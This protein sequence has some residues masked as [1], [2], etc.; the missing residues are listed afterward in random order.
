VR[1][2][3]QFGVLGFS[4]GAIYVALALGLLVI[5]RATA[6]L[7]F[8]QGAMAMWGGYVYTSLRTTGALVLPIGTIH[9]GTESWS[10]ALVLGLVMG[11][12]LSVIV[13]FLVFRPL[14][15]APVLA[16]VVAS[17]AMMIMILSLVQI[18]FGANSLTVPAL[19][20]TG[21]ITIASTSLNIAG[22][23]LA[24]LAIVLC[25][26]AWVFFVFTNAGVA[27]RA[28]SVNERAVMLMGYSP[29]TL[30]LI[31]W[32][33]GVVL[34]TGVVIL[35]SP[36]TGLDPSNYAL[37]VIPALAILLLA[38][39]ASLRT[40]A[41]AGLALGAFQSI[42]TFLSSKTWWPTWGQVGVQD[43]IPFILIVAAL[44]IWGGRLPARGSVDA[45]S[46]PHV[47]L[48][49]LRPPNIIIPLVIAVAA[50]IFT[51]GTYRF[52]VITSLT[53]MLLALSYVLITG[54]LGQISLAQIAFAGASGFILSKI[55]TNWGV[56]F[57]LSIL[58]AALGAGVLGLLLALPAF[59]IRGT[60]LAIVTIAAA[61]TIQEFVFSNPS[62]TPISGNPVSEPS[63]FGLNLAVQNGDDIATLR[64]GL[65]VLI[66]VVIFFGLFIVLARGSTGR[67]WLAVRSNE[68]AAAAAGVNVRAVKLTGFGV[69]AVIAGVAGALIGYSRGQLSADS[70]TVSVGLLL[71]AV[72]YLGG[73]TSLSG[74]MVAGALCNLGIV[75][76]LLNSHITFG[77]YYDLIAG[78]GLVLTTVLNP[79]GIS[80]KTYEQW[81]WVVA[82]YKKRSTGPGGPSE[83]PL[84]TETLKDSEYVV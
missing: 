14:R 17:I 78:I 26:V 7:N 50:L 4:T 64:F 67:A 24:G 45:S 65:M 83:A 21:S 20:S 80:G 59:R 8:A 32:T 16:Q 41:V 60:Q 42:I 56:P 49:S 75:Y 36:A 44:Y 25:I 57:P 19:L 84:S 51:H 58:I 71:L 39:L 18:R 6:V 34:S 43:A 12:L 48:P 73:M 27:M 54:Y 30:G 1:S 33:A 72:T 82:R 74:A 3:I 53:T 61:V 77:K 79:L 38:R 35:A 81:Q 62:L 37:Y 69:S 15:Q 47:R 31:A 11:L 22:L 68:R 10:L 40:I 63:L 5:F 70:F 52:G 9:L 55:T 23:V 66:V 28:A 13:Y 29:S 2:I 76:V 46:L